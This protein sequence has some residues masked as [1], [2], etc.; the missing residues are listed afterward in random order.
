MPDLYSR[1]GGYAFEKNAYIPVHQREIL[2]FWKLL[3]LLLNLLPDREN[4]YI[5]Y[6]KR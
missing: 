5:L 4:M 3:N 6:Y 2:Q 1:T